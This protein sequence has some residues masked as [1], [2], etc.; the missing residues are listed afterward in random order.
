MLYSLKVS[1]RIFNVSSRGRWKAI[2]LL[3]HAQVSKI[4]ATNTKKVDM[5][6]NN[7]LFFYFYFYLSLFMHALLMGSADGKNRVDQY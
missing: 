5:Y 4:K 6:I 2:V 1:T 3:A 7:C